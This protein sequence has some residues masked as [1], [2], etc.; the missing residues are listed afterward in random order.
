MWVNVRVLREEI[1]AFIHHTTISP[2]KVELLTDWLP[3]RGIAAVPV[4]R[5]WR[6]PAA[7][8]WMIPRATSAAT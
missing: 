3:A 4:R 2:T 7:S 5:C 8:G 1:A 6:S